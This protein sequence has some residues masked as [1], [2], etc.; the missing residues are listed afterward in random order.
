MVKYIPKTFSLFRFNLP[1]GLTYYINVNSDNPDK[2]II[3]ESYSFPFTWI[4]KG[5]SLGLKI[6]EY[7]TKTEI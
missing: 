2:P 1:N 3:R 7:Q 5:S 4:I 6:A